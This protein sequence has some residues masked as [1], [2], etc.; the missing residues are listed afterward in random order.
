MNAAHAPAGNAAPVGATGQARP[1]LL[2]GLAVR[3]LL[4][5]AELTPKP[6]LVDRRGGG[7]H[8]DMDLGMLRRSAHA[9]RPTFGA[10]A[11]RAR[12][13]APDQRLREELAAIGRRGEET[14][15]AVT[16]G[17]NTHRGAIWTLGLLTAAAAMA[18]DTGPVRIAAIAGQVAAFPDRH[19][20]SEMSHGSLVAQRYGVPGA[21]GEARSGFPHVV[22]VALPALCAAR[23]AGHPE[24]LARLDALVALIA[25]VDD[26]CLLYRGG[27]AA[28]REAQARARAVLAG[29]GSAN[30][31]GRRALQL[32]E[33][34]LLRQR[35]SPGG[36]ADLLAAALFLDNLDHTAANGGAA[37]VEV[38]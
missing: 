36:S 28:L 30:V 15:F 1:G 33:A 37:P 11:T 27:R 17:V 34:S 13:R 3:A 32:L 7:A 6:A 22:G 24:Q 20:P 9:L 12:G 2:A 31:A 10:L 5:E 19:A 29:G 35:A 25:Y 8:N 23:A 18:P 4:E 21:R 16:H 38:A 26:T 14:M